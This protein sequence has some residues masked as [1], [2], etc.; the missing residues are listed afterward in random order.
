[1]LWLL[2]AQRTTQ[3]PQQASLPRRRDKRYMISS[4]SYTQLP[5]SFV[6]VSYDQALV[7]KEAAGGRPVSIRFTFHLNTLSRRRNL[8]Y[9]TCLTPSYDKVLCYFAK[10]DALLSRSKVSSIMVG[11][12]RVRKFTNMSSNLAEGIHIFMCSRHVTASFFSDP[13]IKGTM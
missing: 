4:F 2:S 13:A 9:I 6:F 12:H 10:Q 5:Y 11:A 3:S 8:R 7:H 1:L